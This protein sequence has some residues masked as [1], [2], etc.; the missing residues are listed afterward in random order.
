M[1]AVTTDGAILLGYAAKQPAQLKVVGQPFS[2]EKYGIGLKK[3]DSAFRGFLDDTLQK[4][5]DNGD[6]KKAY[7][8][9]LG[10]SGSP[11]P[12]PPPLERY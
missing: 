5:F 6:W 7:D 2:T 3:E 8:A 4:A 11:A 9:T 1:D 10:K 12:S